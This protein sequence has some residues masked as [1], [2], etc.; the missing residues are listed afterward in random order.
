MTEF[1]DLQ[2]LR[3]SLPGLEPG[4]PF[5]NL[6]LPAVNDGRPLSLADYRGRKVL[7]HIWASW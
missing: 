3:R 5:P 4:K 6:T 7:L 1:A 2:D